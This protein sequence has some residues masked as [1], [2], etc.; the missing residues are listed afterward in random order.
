MGGHHQRNRQ[1]PEIVGKPNPRRGCHNAFPILPLLEILPMAGQ[2]TAGKTRGAFENAPHFFPA[3]QL[4]PRKT[5]ILLICLR[6]KQIN[7]LKSLKVRKR[8]PGRKLEK[9]TKFFGVSPRRLDG[10]LSSNVAA[11]FEFASSGG[12][13]AILLL[14]NCRWRV[15]YKLVARLAAEQQQSLR[16]LWQNQ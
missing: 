1:H 11:I 15:F 8:G 6:R 3:P 13:E 14:I 16:K 2:R 9:F 5:F 4:R 12:P 10:R 7:R